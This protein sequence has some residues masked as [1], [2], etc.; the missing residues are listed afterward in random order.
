MLGVF[1][2]AGLNNDTSLF[3][4]QILNFVCVCVCVYPQIF[5]RAFSTRRVIPWEALHVGITFESEEWQKKI[6]CIN[7][8]NNH[9]S[10]NKSYYLLKVSHGHLILFYLISATLT[11]MPIT[12]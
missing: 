2:E 6:K 7:N 5:S 9:S 11:A 8:D 3:S 10:S 4:A 12:M 1:K